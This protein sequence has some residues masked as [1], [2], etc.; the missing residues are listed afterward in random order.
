MS[1]GRLG[2]LASRSL[3]LKAAARGLS[4]AKISRALGISL[5]EERRIPQ[6][7]EVEGAG[8]GVPISAAD[9]SDAVSKARKLDAGA[10]GRDCTPCGSRPDHGVAGAVS[11][12]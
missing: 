4:K 3:L 7:G 2:I 12:I 8:A 1:S 10:G 9:N 11:L 6:F 5:P